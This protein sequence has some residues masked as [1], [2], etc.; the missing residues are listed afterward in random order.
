VAEAAVERCSFSGGLEVEGLERRLMPA[1]ATLPGDGAL[2]L[3]LG[4]VTFIEPIALLHL[5]AVLVDRSRRGLLTHLRLPARQR[6]RD[7]LR[8]WNLDGALKLATGSSL[9]HFVGKDDYR[10]FG[11]EQRDYKG[12]QAGSSEEYLLSR[13][14]FGVTPQ[15]V[16]SR[17]T[18]VRLVE[19]E[20]AR[21][22]DPLVLDALRR[23][24]GSAE[25]IAR[26]I[27]YEALTNAVQHPNSNWVA[28]VSKAHSSERGE[29]GRF[30][31]HFF[32][33]GVWDDG[34]SIVQTLKGALQR[35]A[36][37]AGDPTNVDRFEIKTVGWESSQTLYESNWTPTRGASDAELLLASLFQGISQKPVRK[38]IKTIRM[39]GDRTK[40][41]NGDGL[42]ALYRSVIDDFGGS[43]AVRTGAYFMNVK[44]DKG[45][46]PR[47]YRAKI[48]HY[49][50]WPPFPG[51]MITVRVPLVAAV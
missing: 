50:D 34:E 4:K 13:R 9:R 2:D 27:V 23:L 48:S 30:T 39:P 16:G 51:N 26:V 12:V 11:E 7:F 32:Q 10:Y 38:D 45:A 5:F 25:D 18:H 21:W 33:L 3:D 43:L 28:V 29:E 46:A 41:S 37:R 24:R 19:R 1:L 31:D 20:W 6:T 15:R 17:E 8:A 14:F 36:V 35:G 47:T 40:R 42:H 49:G 22:Q 44:A